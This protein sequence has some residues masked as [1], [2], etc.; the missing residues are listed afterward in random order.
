MSIEPGAPVPDE[1]VFLRLRAGA[2]FVGTVTESQLWS[3]PAAAQAVFWTL[4]VPAGS[5]LS[6][7]T[8]KVRAIEAPP[9]ASVPSESV[10]VEPA[11]GEVHDQPEELPAPEKVVLAGTVSERTT[12]AAP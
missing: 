2:P 3:V 11:A 6:I 12:P 1:R 5:G 8:A 10:Q 4:A 9:P 7:T